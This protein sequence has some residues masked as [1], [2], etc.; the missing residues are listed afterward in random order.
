MKQEPAPQTQHGTPTVPAATYSREYFL[1]ECNG[2]EEFLAGSVPPRLQAALRLAGQLEGKKV[3]DVASG[4]GEVIL[5]CAQAGANAHGI[6]YSP[7]ALELARAAWASATGAGHELAHFQLADAQCLPFKEKIF[8]VVFMLDIVEHLH[9]EQLLR[10]LQEA[11]RTLQED[12]LLIIHTMPNVWYYRIGYPLFRLFQRMRGQKLPQDPRQR[13]HFVPAV[14]VN[15]QDIWRLR[16]TLTS[17]G[18]QA[19]VWLQPTQSYDEERTQVVRLFMRILSGCY[20]FR[21][22]FCDDIFALA[23]RAR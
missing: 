15:E 18:F 19:R 10:A 7:D 16:R 12:G 21:W 2:H 13:W 22:V 9:S 6:D 23:R 11:H 17:A 3:L 5:Y 8:D 14:H 1:T 20:P 4:R